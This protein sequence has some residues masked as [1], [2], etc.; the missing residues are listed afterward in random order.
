MLE[1]FYVTFQELS[2]NFRIWH[3]V[4]EALFLLCFCS[5]P[6]CSAVPGAVVLGYVREILQ[7]HFFQFGCPFAH[8]KNGLSF[9][10]WM[11]F[12]WNFNILTNPVLSTFSKSLTSLS[13]HKNSKLII[14]QHCADNDTLLHIVHQRRWWEV[15]AGQHSQ[16]HTPAGIEG[17]KIDSIHPG[18]REHPSAISFFWIHTILHDI[19]QF[20]TIITRY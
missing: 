16:I 3:P 19:L 9:A 17:L 7:H 10:S 2:L 12:W 20:D 8:Y 6:Q 4:D 11:A 14:E 5:A 1:K 18:R 13:Y 15:S